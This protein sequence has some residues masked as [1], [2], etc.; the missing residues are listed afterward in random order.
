MLP[1][2]YLRKKPKALVVMAELWRRLF[3]ADPRVLGRRI[4]A[5]GDLYTVIG[6]MPPTFHHPGQ[7][8]RDAVFLT[9]TLE[10]GT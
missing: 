10:P 8:L 1:V 4:S 7:T 5:D 9:I 2:V 3:G 6:V